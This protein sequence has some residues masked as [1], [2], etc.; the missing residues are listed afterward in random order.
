MIDI[1]FVIFMGLIFGSFMNVLIYRLPRGISIITPRSYCPLCQSKINMFDNIPLISFIMLK[2]KCRNCGGR[3]SLRY[4]IVEVTYT[5]VLL[6][7]LLQF[8]MTK[9]FLYFAIFLF[10]AIAAAFCDI[11]TLLDE[12]FETGIIPDSLN[13]IGILAGLVLSFFLY[14]NFLDSLLGAIIGFLLLYVPNVIYRIFRKADGIGG[15][16]MKLLALCG[17]FLGYKSILFVLLIGSFTGAILGI[18]IIMFTK[19]KYFPIPFG[20]FIALGAIITIYYNDYFLKVL[21][22]K[23][24]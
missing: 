1:I 16:D 14:N 4:P 10:F 20:P 12:K 11:Y 8:G 13:Y 23:V 6:C 7:L 9:D 22:L 5:I 21:G 24:M 3:I 15:G 2:G 18:L 19:N 17:A